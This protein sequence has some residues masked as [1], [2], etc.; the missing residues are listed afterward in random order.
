MLAQQEAFVKRCQQSLATTSVAAIHLEPHL[1]DLPG[2]LLTY[3]PTEEFQQE[4]DLLAEAELVMGDYR[5]YDKVYNNYKELSGLTVNFLVNTVHFRLDCSKGGQ[6]IVLVSFK[7]GDS[8]LFT[9]NI[10]VDTGAM[11][12]FI[13]KDFVW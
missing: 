12:N 13:S 3:H 8:S 1:A 6:L 9:A 5:N 2:P 11:A 7:T 10:L 4:S